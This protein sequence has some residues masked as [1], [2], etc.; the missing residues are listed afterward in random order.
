MDIHDLKMRKFVKVLEQPALQTTCMVWI[1]RAG[2]KL[3]HRNCSHVDVR[4]QSAS[5]AEQQDM[6]Y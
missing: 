1:F 5:K 2:Q 4:E 6:N 3:D